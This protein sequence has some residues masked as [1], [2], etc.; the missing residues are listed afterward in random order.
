MGEAMSGQEFEYRT[1]FTYLYLD[2]VRM[3]V[4][5]LF[6]PVDDIRFTINRDC[7]VS[8]HYPNPRMLVT[9]LREAAKEAY[10]RSLRSKDWHVFDTRKI[11]EWFE[12]LIN[13][14]E[15]YEGDLPGEGSNL[16]SPIT[17]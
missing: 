5:T 16:P 4:P 9:G 1:P 14:I 10:N 12:Q 3:K 8:V 17:G 13:H 7:S 2:Y 6:D 11:E 15:Q